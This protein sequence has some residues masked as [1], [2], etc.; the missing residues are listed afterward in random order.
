[1]LKEE[2][3]PIKNTL[4]ENPSLGVEGESFPDKQKVMKFIPT[5]LALQEMLKGLLQAETKE[6]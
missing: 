4:P 6:C 3:L 1:M 2:K 5:R